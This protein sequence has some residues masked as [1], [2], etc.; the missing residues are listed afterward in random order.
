[1]PGHELGTLPNIS[2]NHP[3]APRG[4]PCY[5]REA[6]LSRRAS[7]ALGC[8]AALPPGVKGR[9]RGGVESPTPCTAGPG[10]PYATAFLGANETIPVNR[11]PPGMARSKAHTVAL[12][13]CQSPTP[14]ISIRSYVNTSGLSLSR[15]PLPCDLLSPA[16]RPLP[17]TRTSPRDTLPGPSWL[18]SLDQYLWVPWVEWI[19]GV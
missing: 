4:P 14:D 10:P 12:L 2:L 16:S 9:A 6:P 7:P 11:L 8:P 17:G 3:A 13:T 1:M 18:E 19:Q 15:S 5:Q